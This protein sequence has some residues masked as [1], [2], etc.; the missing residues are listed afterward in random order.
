VLEWGGQL[1][2]PAALVLPAPAPC[3]ELVGCQ[4]W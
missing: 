4:A 3:H 2:V 1:V